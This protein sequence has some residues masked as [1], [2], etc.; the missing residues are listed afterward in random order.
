MLQLPVM[1]KHLPASNILSAPIYTLGFV[2]LFWTIFD[3]SLTYVTPLLIEQRGF[4]PTAVGIIIGTSSM[5]GAL[6]DIVGSK[7]FKDIRFKTIFTFL[8][9]F[10]FAYPFFLWQAN[11]ITGFLLAMSIWGIYYDLYGFGTFNFVGKHIPKESQSSSFGV[12]QTFRSLGGIIGPIIIGLLVVETVSHEPFITSVV[13]LTI[14][15]LIYFV[16]IFKLQKG[17]DDADHKKKRRSHRGNFFREFYLLKKLGVQIFPILL[18]T[19]YLFFIESFFWTLG[20]IYAESGELGK[21]GGVFLTAFQLPALLIGWFVG[22]LVSRYTEKT[23]ALYGLLIGTGVLSFF[24]L[25][26]NAFV[27]TL[28]VFVSSLFTSAALPAVNTIYSSMIADKPDLDSEIES[29]EDFSFNSGYVFGPI[30][31]GSISDALSIPIAFSLLGLLGVI[32]SGLLIVASHRG[33]ILRQN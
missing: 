20:P 4:S 11:S 16:L 29:I 26:P 19:F 23:I 12:I 25:A 32:I 22:T 27:A 24:M 1:R 13:F 17:I 31:A 3:S 2:V 33:H 10:C 14:A 6:F 21:L 30:L 5:F 18:V 15:L 7:I 28:L 8:F 9:A